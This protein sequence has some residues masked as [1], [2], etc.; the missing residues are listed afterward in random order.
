MLSSKFCH[1]RISVFDQRSPVHPVSESRGGLLSVTDEVRT[2]GRKSSCLISG[3]SDLK[4]TV[5]KLI[6]E[7]TAL[8]LFKIE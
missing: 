2:D 1:L 6:A 7:V 4:I 8:L 5:E 3:F